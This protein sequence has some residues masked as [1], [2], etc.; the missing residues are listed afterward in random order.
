MKGKGKRIIAVIVMISMVLNIMPG[1]S[2]RIAKAAGFEQDLVVNGNGESSTA[3]ETAGTYSGWIATEGSSSTFTIDHYTNLNWNESEKSSNGGNIFDFYPQTLGVSD[4]LYQD[5]DVSD[6]SSL[7]DTGAISCNFGGEVRRFSVNSVAAIRVSFFNASDTQILSNEVTCDSTVQNQWQLKNDTVQV[8]IG[9]V[10]IRISLY[11]EILNTDTADVISDYSEFDGIFLSLKKNP[12]LKAS[13]SGI[14]IAN[15]GILQFGS[16]VKG[17]SVEKTITIDNTGLVALHINSANSQGTDFADFTATEVPTTEIPVGSSSTFKITYT[18]SKE[19]DE[20]ACLVLSSD[21]INS[22]Y[23]INMYGTGLAIPSLPTVQDVALSD[24]GEVTWTDIEHE[25]GYSAQ[26]YKSSNPVGTAVT[27]S[28]NATSC[29]MLSVMQSNGPGTYS[30]KVTAVGDGTNYADSVGSAS[31]TKTVI[32][33]D[34]VT[35]G[36]TWSG[37]VA[38][39]AAVADATKYFVQLYKDGIAIDNVNAKQEVLAA[40]IID[41]VDFSSYITNDEGGTFTYTVTA[42]GDG[43]L[44][45]DSVVSNISNNNIKKIKLNKVTGVNISDEGILTF[46]GVDHAAGYTIKLYSV[47]NATPVDTYN[48]TSTEFSINVASLMPALGDYTVEVIAKGDNTYYSDSEAEASNQVT[49][50][51]AEKADG[52]T[53]NGKVAHWNTVVGTNAYDVKLYEGATLK[54]T[55]QVLAADIANGANFTS[56]MGYNKSYTFTVT[57]LGNGKLIWP[58]EESAQSEVFYEKE[59]LAKVVIAGFVNGVLTWNDVSNEN[60]YSIK[61]YRYNNSN[62]QYEEV[63]AIDSISQNVATYNLLDTM[64]TLGEGTYKATVT[65]RSDGS[66]YVDGPESEASS[67]ITIEKLATVSAGLTWE[68]Y[69]AKWVAVANAL[70]Y[71]V[72]L[73]KDGAKEG[74]IVNIPASDIALGADFESVIRN[75]EAG[76]YTYKVTAKGTGLFLDAEESTSSDSKVKFAQVTNLQFSSKGV[77]TWIPVANCS[78]YKVRLYRNSVDCNKTYNVGAAIDYSNIMRSIGEGSYTVTVTPLGNGTTYIDG[79]TSAMSNPQSVT[80]LGTPQNLRWEGNIATWD[81]VP[82]A[83]NYKVQY[84]K[85]SSVYYTNSITGTSVDFTSDFSTGTGGDYSVIVAAEEMD[86]YVAGNAATSPI[87]K[88]PKPLAQVTGVNLSTTGVASWVDVDNESGYIV[89]LF[90][91]NQPI[92]P[93]YNLGDN[94]ENLNLLSDMRDKGVGSYTVMV[95]AKGDD[96]NFS[97][98]KPSPMSSAISISKL[99]TVNTGLTWTGDVAHWTGVA[100][101]SSYDVQLYKAGSKLGPV[102]NI[103]AALAASGADFATTIAAEGGGIYTYTVT[104]KGELLYLDASSSVQ[105]N[106]NIEPYTLSQVTNVSISEQGIVTWNQVAH[107]NGYEIG[108]YKNNAYEGK[109]A[110]I[111]GKDITSKDISQILRS[112]GEGSYQVVV[113]AKGDGT[114]YTDGSFSDRSDAK[115]VTRLSTVKGLYWEGNVAHWATV[116]NASSYE[117]TLY[118]DGV[119]ES[120]TNNIVTNSYDF[121]SVFTASTGGTYNFEVSAKGQKLFLDGPTSAKSDD[122]VVATPLSKVTSVSLSDKGEASWTDIANEAGYAVQLYRNGKPFGATINTKA[123]VTI[124]NLLSE[125]RGAGAGE[126]SVT[127]VALGDGIFY[128]DSIQSGMSNSQVVELPNASSLA[129][130]WNKN[131]AHW[132]Q[133]PNVT[134]Y[135]IQLVKNSNTLIGAPINVSQA[136]VAAGVDFTNQIVK[137]GIGSYTFTITA[138]GDANLVLDTLPYSDQSVKVIYSITLPTVTA[139][140]NWNGSI[141]RWTPVANAVSYLVQLYK[142]G[143]AVGKPEI[144]SSANVAAGVNFEKSIQNAG[145]GV[146]TYTVTAK[147]DGT[148]LIDAAESSASDCNVHLFSDTTI[149]FDLNTAT[150]NYKDVTITLPSGTSYNLTSISNGKENL[151]ISKDYSITGNKVTITKEYLAKQQQGKCYF[152]FLFDMDKEQVLSIL[153]TRTPEQGTG[154]TGAPTTGS[155]ET[156][157]RTGI[158]LDSGNTMNETI[159]RIIRFLD[160]NGAGKVDYSQLGEEEA[161][162]FLAHISLE[163]AMKAKIAIRDIPGDPADCVNVELLSKFL[164][165][166]STTKGSLVIDTDKADIELTPSTIMQNRVR[167][168]NVS[169]QE[170]TDNTSLKQTDELLLTFA[171][172]GECIGD[173]YDVSTN[174]TGKT[175][176]TI[177]ISRSDVPSSRSGQRTFVKSLSVLAQYSD[178]ENRLQKGTIVYDSNGI[179]TGYTVQVEGSSTFTLV[180]AYYNTTYAVVSKEQ[181]VDKV[182][183]FNFKGSMDAATI[184]EDNLYVLDAKGNKV[185]VTLRCKGKKVTITPAKDSYKPGETYTMYF[186]TNVKYSN[187]EALKSGKAYQFTIKK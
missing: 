102:K 50:K 53:W 131:V 167:D 144:V 9:T 40:N 34:K 186:T 59:P 82:N 45:L 22:N 64:R 99:A 65:A 130:R 58:G 127:V 49:V 105:S 155:T 119:K 35:T 16:A 151:Q 124:Q 132:T 76:T 32:K 164:E 91:D 136:D 84:L 120:T 145:Y 12:I 94:V 17:H 152:T 116:A 88:V 10:R 14:E 138:I 79:S 126:Y 158:L 106:E 177:P 90:K 117:I 165:L 137:E 48:A 11:G 160:P 83:T 87:K 75:G 118:K 166:F 159:C 69:K 133:L 180:T 183:S 103:D 30:V 73:Y 121:S 44:H 46:T 149:V 150:T 100:N 61:L 98:G 178:G 143:K 68:G 15:S 55:L 187:G 60:G 42:I 24:Q 97:N 148:F 72:Q 168:L 128:S 184:T 122:K 57:A 39:W 123:N 179:P 154:S 5:I 141:A 162:N 51:R 43:I 172:R 56:D 139:G 129:P 110:E 85:D 101:A 134:K 170:V 176:I 21:A 169:I 25:S 135:T 175:Y 38:H 74:I 111:I 67:P 6:I 142:D 107:N 109:F 93:V 63:T 47:G 147:G 185:K 19:G 81:A 4:T 181:K 3:G 113:S 182:W 86:L 89:Q 23:I 1:F 108:L 29:N 62:S 92:T 146:Y 171:V 174:I 70:S 78:S 115:T 140:L 8:P 33:L 41:G 31:N 71:D 13:E 157:S 114:Y 112:K 163:S 18:P 104:A 36:L 125:M 96:V 54:K 27:L 77:V 173:T 20:A 26:L 95:T 80:K 153:I 66:V 7:I 2:V 156:N 52:L 28:E 37:N 161:K